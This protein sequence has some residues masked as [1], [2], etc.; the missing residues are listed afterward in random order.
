MENKIDVKKEAD[1]IFLVEKNFKILQAKKTKEAC[2]ELVSVL[3]I[4]KS[5]AMKIIQKIKLD[6][7]PNVLWI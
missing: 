3:G 6:S 4:E 7:I 1:W 2:D 5:L